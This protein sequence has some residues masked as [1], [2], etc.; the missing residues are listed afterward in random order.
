M[1]KFFNTR[2]LS[3]IQTVAEEVV[4]SV[5][6]Q[7]ITLYKMSVGESRTNLYG[8]SIGKVYHAPSNLMCIVDRE[9]QS[10]SYEGF[11]ASKDQTVVFAF[12]RHQLRT[13]DLPKIRDVNG[14]LITADTIQNTLHGYP[15]IGDVVSFDNT[16]YEIDHIKETKLVSGSPQLFDSGSASFEDTRMQLVATAVMVSRTSVQLEERIS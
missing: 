10:V 5:V 2:D 8:E 7:W 12:M 3:F 16:F 1:P 4:D 11:G 6:E 9:P 15:E 13:L 14:T